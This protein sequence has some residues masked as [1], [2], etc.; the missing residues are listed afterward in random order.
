MAENNRPRGRQ[1][2]VLSGSGKVEKRG[3]GLGTGPVGNRKTGGVN[4]AGGS[5][6]GRVRGSASGG[7]IS[8]GK[9]ILIIAVLLLGGG[10]AGAGLLGTMGGSTLSQDEYSNQDGYSSQ[11]GYGSQNGSTQSS[12]FNAGE[13]LGQLSGYDLS[14]AYVYDSTD[15]SGDASSYDASLTAEVDENVSA[16][17][18]SKY[19]SIVGGGADQNTI[20]VYI[21]GTDLESKSGMAT[22][23]L[24]EMANATISGNVNI[25]CYTGGCKSWK[26][27]TVSSKV[28]QIYQVKSGGIKLLEDN[29]GSDPMTKPETLTTFIKYCSENYPANRYD[30]IFWDHGGG[31]L[32]GYG[33]DEKNSS[34]GSMSLAGINTALKNAGVKFDF[35]GFDACLMATVENA[36]MLADYGDYMIASEETEP[37]VGWYYTNWITKL[38][39][40]PS[41]PTLQIGKNIVDDFVDVC[42]K[43]CSGQKATLSV[44]DLAECEAKIPEPL[45]KFSAG[46]AELI[47][48]DEGYSK[49]SAARNNTKEFA[50]SSKIDQIDFVH[51]TKLL[52]TTESNE[53]AEALSSC[54]KYNRTERT[55]QNANGLSIYFP[56]KKASKTSSMISTYDAI[57]MDKGYSECIKAF[58]NSEQSG[59]MTLDGQGSALPSLFGSLYGSSYADSSGGS[60]SDYAGSIEGLLTA[61][62]GRGNIAASENKSVS[63]NEGF[64]SAKLEITKN[65]SGQKVIKLDEEDWDK[66]ALCD[67]NVFADD[68]EG[69]I[70]LGL[71]NT[72]EYDDEGNLVAEYDNT[73]MSVNGQIVAYYHTDTEDDG[74]NYSINGYVPAFLN[75]ERVELLV[76]FNSDNPNGTITGA[77][78]VYADGSTDA[79]AKNLVAP[80]SG[81]TI[82]FICD[83]YDYDGNYKNSY[84][85]GEPLILDSD[86]FVIGNLSIGDVNAR[87]TYVFTDLY[88]QQYWSP[89]VQ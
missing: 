12:D 9:I 54:V 48:T 58:A 4:G 77:R 63:V 36:L 31:S 78:Y 84:Y 18:R 71:D 8:L 73:W 49:V 87:V 42:A 10:G 24:Q 50:Q 34:Y 61:L 70:D 88:Q 72:I 19:T 38:S 40:N 26:N 51:F 3:E 41:L 11:D 37:G 79:V 5:A 52:N 67:L 59:Q 29:M 30:L 53:L 80:K 13:L 44:V 22:A 55:I 68:G 17:A 16:A 35:I 39:E 60:Y 85:L 81:D 82:E 2:N 76:S 25:I 28:N 43:K 66:I 46:T 1:K 23:D 6:G 20:M 75:G 62:M 89:V 83:Y 74:E 15:T 27:T 57:G 7:K 86:E 32:S 64:D 33:Y 47:G 21:C 65:Q 69:F 56:Y 14:Q 45:S